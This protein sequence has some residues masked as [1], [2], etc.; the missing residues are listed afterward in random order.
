VPRLIS[1][2]PTSHVIIPAD[3]TDPVQMRAVARAAV[4][5]FGGIDV[6][7]NNAGL[8]LWGRFADISVEAQRRLIE[9]NLMA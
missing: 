1:L 3:V 4:E 9:A 5:A 8:S 6:W 7:I 2:Y